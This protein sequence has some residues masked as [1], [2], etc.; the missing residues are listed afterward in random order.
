[1]KELAR[2]CSGYL[3]KSLRR[4]LV[5]LEFTFL[6]R[7]FN[8]SPMLITVLIDGF[9]KVVSINDKLLIEKINRKETEWLIFL[10][11]ISNIPLNLQL[12]VQKGRILHPMKSMDYKKNEKAEFIVNLSLNLDFPLTIITWNP[13]LYLV[14]KSVMYLHPPL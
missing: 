8:S 1:L 10:L 3:S 12:C 11:I 9:A 6:K 14:R 4:F 2:G 7:V 13:R 5:S